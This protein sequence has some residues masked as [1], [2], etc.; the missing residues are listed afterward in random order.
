MTGNPD[1]KHA[2]DWSLIRLAYDRSHRSIPGG[3]SGNGRHRADG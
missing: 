3:H 1:A 2:H